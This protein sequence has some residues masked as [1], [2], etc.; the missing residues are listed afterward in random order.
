MSTS[1]N[2]KKTNI[3][4]AGGSRGLG[5]ALL[6][7]F[8]SR[9]FDSYALHRGT[10][11][12]D[13]TNIHIDIDQSSDAYETS[14]NALES[15]LAQNLNSEVCVHFVSGGGLGTSLVNGDINDIQ[16]V[17]YHNYSFPAGLSAFL[18]QLAQQDQYCNL[19][20]SLFFYSS[21]VTQ[22]CSANPFYCAAKSALEAFYKSSFLVRPRNV[23]M[24]MF[25]L[26]IVDIQ[27]KYFHRLSQEKPQEFASI[28][29]KQ[30]PSGYVLKP[31]EVSS[32]AAYSALD[33]N[34]CNGVICD[35]T[36]GNSWH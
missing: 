16:R 24:Y 8:A 30:L 21:A 9:G 6:N 7:E 26:G 3:V 27:H 17:L 23:F 18:M 10:P 20:L 13:A 14:T 2:S 25:R 29:S 1:S 11:I 22:H 28:L 32:F 34:A 31:S 4:V 12:N 33:T 35:I 19:K 36:G 15:I 5:Q